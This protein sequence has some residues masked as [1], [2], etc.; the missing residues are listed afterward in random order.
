MSDTGRFEQ[1]AYARLG[2]VRTFGAIGIAE[3]R[4]RG[5][6]VSSGGDQSVVGALDI[7]AR[8][9]GREVD[10]EVAEPR[11]VEDAE[12][13]AHCFRYSPGRRVLVELLEARRHGLLGG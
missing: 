8:M 2:G 7:E 5:A 3:G 9:E 13:R 12:I 11:V 6:P 4:R 1:P 10:R